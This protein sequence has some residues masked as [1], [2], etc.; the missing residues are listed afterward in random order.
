MNTAWLIRRSQ[1]GK[2]LVHKARAHTGSGIEVLNRPEQNG[3]QA[4]CMKCVHG[5]GMPYRNCVVEV[6]R[7]LGGSGSAHGY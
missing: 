6:P 1:S 2:A 4:H 5:Y 7:P 3:P